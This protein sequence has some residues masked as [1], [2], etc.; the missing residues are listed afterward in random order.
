MFKGV[1]T[2]IVTPF[3]NG[4]IDEDSLRKMTERQIEN[5]IDGIVPCGTTGE[6]PVLSPE[7]FKRVISVVVEQAKGRVPVIAGTGTNSTSA[8]MEKTKT[9]KNL[10]ADGAL[11]VAPYYNKPTQEG[12]FEHFRAVA[13]EGGLPVV[14]YNIPSRTGVNIDPQT[15]YRCSYIDGIAAVKEASGSFSQVMEIRHLCGDKLIILSGDDGLAL[16]FYTAG[17]EGVVSVASNVVPDLMKKMDTDYKNGLI[18]DAALLNKKLYP[19]F[20]ALFIETNPI[21]VKF[22]MKLLG[23]CTDEMRLPLTTASEKTRIEL[24]KV[25]KELGLYH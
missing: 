13:N 6:S 12:L 1:F 21:P 7:E 2:A 17:A 22:A 25:L 15:L 4:M 9:A 14:I 20:K 24:Q 11:V 10:K 8:S 5:G 3:R 19:L 23:M 16:P 18:K